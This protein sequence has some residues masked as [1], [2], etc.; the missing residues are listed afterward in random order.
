[1]ELHKLGQFTY[2]LMQTTEK[3]IFFYVQLGPKWTPV[4]RRLVY[5]NMAANSGLHWQWSIARRPLVPMSK[6][7]AQWNNRIETF[8]FNRSL[9]E[10]CSLRCLPKTLWTGCQPSCLMYPHAQ[11]AFN[12]LCSPSHWSPLPLFPGTTPTITMPP[13]SLSR[14]T[15]PK[16]R[17][18]RFIMLFMI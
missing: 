3:T 17:N 8:F 15:W 4:V 13:K 5:K 14:L 12:F 16:C 1:M 2:C 6:P 10:P 11:N 18:F 9:T 7:G